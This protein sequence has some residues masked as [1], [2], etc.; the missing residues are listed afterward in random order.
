MPLL[1]YVKRQGSAPTVELDDE[2][3]IAAWAVLLKDQQE[4]NDVWSILFHSS[5]KL[6]IHWHTSNQRFNIDPS[7]DIDL[8][9]LAFC[10]W[11]DGDECTE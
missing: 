8:A 9:L 11:E 10:S 6:C 1:G 2:A 5:L 3:N 7:L 4:D